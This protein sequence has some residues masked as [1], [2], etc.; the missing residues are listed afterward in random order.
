MLVTGLSG[1]G[2]SNTLKFLEDIG[3]Y[4]TDNLP[5]SLVPTYLNYFNK[6]EP[7]GIFSCASMAYET[8]RSTIV[9]VAIGVHLRDHDSLALFQSCYQTLS[10]MVDHMELLFIEANLDT[11]VSRYRETRR[12]HPLEKERTVQETIALERQYLEP[13]RAM[14]DLVIETSRTTVPQLKDRL[15]QLFQEDL[16]EKPDHKKL[17]KANLTIFIR[18]FGFKYGVNTDVDMVLDGRFLPN[19]HYDLALRPF[20]GC[21]TPIIHVLEKALLQEGLYQ[22]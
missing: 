4:W 2:K 7:D 13:I 18:S 9:R 21:D 22:G 8:E 1:A 3:F 11:L 12:R 16:S 6:N 5:L 17:H 10:A 20:R 14:A 19:P 15:E